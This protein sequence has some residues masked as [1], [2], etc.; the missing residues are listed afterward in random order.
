MAL[1]DLAEAASDSTVLD[2]LTEAI[3]AITI[4]ELVQSVFDHFPYKHSSYHALEETGRPALEHL[5][6]R[7]LCGKFPILWSEVALEYPNT[8]A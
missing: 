7:Q 5:C 3:E 8:L 2:S 6:D 1:T 4:S